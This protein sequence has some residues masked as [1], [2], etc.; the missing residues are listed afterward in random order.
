MPLFPLKD[1]VVDA[2][3]TQLWWLQRDWEIYKWEGHLETL[4]DPSNPAGE[5]APPKG[6]P[7]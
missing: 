4:P 1:Y 6:S 2:F 5:A 7:F 3:N